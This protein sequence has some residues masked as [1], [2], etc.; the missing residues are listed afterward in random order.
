MAKRT[1]AKAAA[2]KTK[3]GKASPARAQAGKTA[4]RKQPAKRKPTKKPGDDGPPWLGPITDEALKRQPDG[5]PPMIAEWHTAMRERGDYVLLWAGAMRPPGEQGDR[6]WSSQWV[7]IGYPARDEDGDTQRIS[8]TDA[9]SAA[10]VE[11]LLSPLAH[12]ARVRLLQALYDGPRVSS[13]LTAVTG[14]RGGNLYHHLKELIHAGHVSERDSGYALTNVGRQ[15]LVTVTCIAGLIIEDR[16]DEGL[17][18]G[19]SWGGKR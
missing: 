18:A 8:D 12:E 15:L 3:A 5:P 19:S 16:D 13:E 10:K 11:R 17:V 9:E 4:G 7:N 2:R 1:T 6:S 14:L